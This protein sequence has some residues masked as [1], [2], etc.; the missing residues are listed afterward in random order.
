MIVHTYSGENNY[1]HNTHCLFSLYSYFRQ[2]VLIVKA[3]LFVIESNANSGKC[4][5]EDQFSIEY[6]LTLGKFE[7]LT[8]CRLI[9]YGLVSGHYLK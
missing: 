5:L 9:F 3:I 7:E 6:I 1:M 8:A 4:V 2:L